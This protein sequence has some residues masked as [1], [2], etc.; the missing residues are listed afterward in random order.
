[1]TRIAQALAL[2]GIVLFAVGPTLAAKPV[3]GTVTL[4]QT[5]PA[6]GDFVDFHV[7]TDVSGTGVR[8]ECSQAGA[9]VGISSTIWHYSTFDYTSERVGLYS[10]IWTG[11]AADCVAFLLEVDATPQNGYKT[12]ASTGFSVSP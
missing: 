2:V 3:H 11:G 1:M 10:P 6:Y 7:T 9:V 4:N 5:A 8:V 12:I